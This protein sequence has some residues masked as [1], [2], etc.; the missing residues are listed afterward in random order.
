VVRGEVLLVGSR[1]LAG[2]PVLLA[3]A[4]DVS[5]EE[6]QAAVPGSAVHIEILRCVNVDHGAGG[7]SGVVRVRVDSFE[8]DNFKVRVNVRV[9]VFDNFG[10]R[11]FGVGER[12]FPNEAGHPDLGLLLH[13]TPRPEVAVV[14]PEAL[15]ALFDP[16]FRICVC[17][18]EARAPLSG[19]VVQS[20]EIDSFGE[21]AGNEL[22]KKLRAEILLNW[23]EVFW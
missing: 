14:N 13:V 21:V 6:L 8:I 1:P 4:P 12:V 9:V 19:V 7:R 5:A 20:A 10:D 16:S 17:D 23:C 15:E 22:V 11:G 3:E 18:D 2:T